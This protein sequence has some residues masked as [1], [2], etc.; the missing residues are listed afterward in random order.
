MAFLTFRRKEAQPVAPSCA[1]CRH[2]RNDAAYLEQQMPGIASLSSATASV[3]SDDGL[4]AY[5][6]RW[7]SLRSV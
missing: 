3:R 5:H 4:C 2:F 7:Q 1:T 6:D